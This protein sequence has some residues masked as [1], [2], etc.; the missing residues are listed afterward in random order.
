MIRRILRKFLPDKAFQKPNRLDHGRMYMCVTVGLFLTS[1]SMIM[2]GPLP[3][4]TISR[5]SEFTQTS[6]AYVLSLCSATCL[7]GIFR[8]TR[9]FMPRADL[10]DSYLMAKWSIPG[11][12][13]SLGTYVVAIFVNYGSIWLST[14]SGSIGASILIGSLWNGWDF[15]NEIDRLDAELKNEVKSE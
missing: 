12:G 4:S 7:V 2:L 14:V 13:A 10:R 1:L 9:F 11:I 6:M 3:N 8:G 15:A 5:L